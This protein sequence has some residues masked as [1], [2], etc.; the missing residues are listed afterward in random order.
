[1]D[2][3]EKKREMQAACDVIGSEVSKTSEV[4]NEVVSVSNRSGRGVQSAHGLDAQ[5]ALA[6]DK[7]ALGVHDCVVEESGEVID[8]ATSISNRRG[9]KGRSSAAR[10]GA[11]QFDSAADNTQYRVLISPEANLAVDDL[12]GHV[13]SGFDGGKVTRPQLVSWILCKFARTIAEPDL[14]EIRAVHFDRIAYFEALL[15]RAKETGEVP[16]ELAALLPASNVTM[17]NGR[18]KRSV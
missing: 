16:P 13:N 18:K 1:M 12:I 17:N 7:T 5:S 10:L 11:D 6:S 4:L 2:N 15:K 9:R 14:Q 8:E 3:L